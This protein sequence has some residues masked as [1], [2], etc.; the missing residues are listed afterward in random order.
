[1]YFSFKA[2]LNIRIRRL[3]FETEEIELTYQHINQYFFGKL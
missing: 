2:S 1:M 3:Y